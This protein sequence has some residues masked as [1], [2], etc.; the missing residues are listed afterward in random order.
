MLE[1]HSTIYKNEGRRILMFDIIM[2]VF[3]VAWL[4]AVCAFVWMET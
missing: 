1:L 2:E 3:T 4:L